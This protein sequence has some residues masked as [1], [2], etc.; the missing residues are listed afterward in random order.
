MN[1]VIIKTR[2]ILLA[3]TALLA[4]T[5]ASAQQFQAS[6]LKKAATKLKF[7]SS[8]LA[9]DTLP[10][11]LQLKAGTQPIVARI[12]SKGVVEH[13]GVPLFAEEMRQLQPSPIYDYLEFTVLD[14]LYKVNENT[15]TLQDLK[16]EKGTLAQLAKVYDDADGCSIE[17]LADKY[18]RVRWTKGETPIVMVS[19]PINYELLANSNRKEMELNFIRDIK[20]FTDNT[21]VTQKDLSAQMV[22]TKDPDLYVVPGDH[23]LIKEINTNRYLTVN[24]K[25]TDGGNEHHLGFVFERHQPQ[26]SFANLMVEPDMPIDSARMEL[27]FVLGNYKR[28]TVN[29]ALHD[30]MAFCRKQGCQPYFGFEENKDGTLTGTLIMRNKQ[31]GYDHIIAV[32]AEE[33][34]LFAD[35]P[36]VHAKVHLFTPSTNVRNLFGKATKSNRPRIKYA[37]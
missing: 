12:D 23:Y 6:H 30:W 34:E 24:S 5:M 11:T 26:E 28:D 32:R 8:D 14:R 1:N 29:V 37:Q 19:F 33:S 2:I 18:Y 21:P 35:H 20:T 17:N 27:V 7:S 22:A 36:L 15:L 10:S 25:D 16:F 13:L 9:A 3:A 4:A 31:S